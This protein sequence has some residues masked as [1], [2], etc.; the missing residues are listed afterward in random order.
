[1]VDGMLYIE[2]STAAPT[3][4]LNLRFWDHLVSD[5][6]TV[7]PG[8]PMFV[9]ASEG[10]FFEGSR[11]Y[12]VFTAPLPP[13]DSYGFFSIGEGKNTLARHWYYLPTDRVRIRADLQDGSLLF[14]GP[15]AE[16]YR[17][18]HDLDRVFQEQL[19]NADPVLIYSK[20]ESLFQDSLSA[21]LWEQAQ[22]RP[23]DLYVRMQVIST[24]EEAWT[25]FRRYIAF[26]FTAHSA[27]KALAY[28]S[29]VLTG[30]QQAL[31][32]ARIKGEVL[33]RAMTKL[34]AASELIL[35][36][37]DKF[38]LVSDW[39]AQMDLGEIRYSHPLLAQGTYQWAMLQA[40]ADKQQF[41]EVLRPLAPQLREEV[42][43]FYLLDNF[44]R[45]GD[46]LPGLIQSS[47]TMVESPW[48]KT[49]LEELLQA[50]SGQFTAEG[51][52]RE[53]GDPVDL[54]QFEGKTLLIHF[55]ISG[56]KFCIYE[57][58]QVM[59]DLSAQYADD[60]NILI[61]TVNADVSGENWKKSL[62]T[63]KYTSESSLN[64]WVPQGTG[65]L[66]TYSIHSFPQK[67]L[68]NPDGSIQLQTI[69]HLTIDELSDKLE[70]TR[71]ESTPAFSQPQTTDL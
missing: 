68:V 41:L 9:P 46:Q 57:Y 60:P 34:E 10:N 13:A 30:E 61:L 35:G 33:F 47:M 22:S 11:N 48:L 28:R 58:Q 3:D 56:C 21:A 6:R 40:F 31:L 59:R 50:N 36:D 37:P 71:P 39:V 67:M 12:C 1:M 53:N 64:L 29:D 7:T 65:L 23:E 44:N 62:A 25:E 24:A 63:G 4:S 2:L 70:N 16:F 55:W 18:Q 54:S 15:D 38:R 20:P 49:R 17:A 66:K 14:G 27:W 32:Q 69:N 19:F 45:M 26:P 51:L 52:Q 8:S 43:A 42:I 5:R